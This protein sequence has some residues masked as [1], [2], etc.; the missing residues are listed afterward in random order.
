MD[1][2][3]QN[4][5]NF[6]DEEDFDYVPDSDNEKDDDVSD[7]EDMEKILEIKDSIDN[8][9][10]KD[11]DNKSDIESEEDDDE[12]YKQLLEAGNKKCEVRTKSIENN[13]PTTDT[14]T[15]VNSAPLKRSAK[16]SGLLDIAESTKKKKISSLSKCAESWKKYVT[17]K[18][19]SDE[20][21]TFNKGKGGFL[22]RQDFLAKTDLKQ[23]EK[24]RE[25]RNALRKSKQ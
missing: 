5:D 12:I 17:T 23:F 22:A 9:I 7:E 1:K 21:A 18:G 2:E 16:S 4:D 8:E 3:L 11:S 25:A 13:L 6:S 10:K 24:E 14:I 19:I 15:H 20:L